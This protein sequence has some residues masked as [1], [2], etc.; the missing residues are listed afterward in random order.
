MLIKFRKQMYSHINKLTQHCHN[1][2]CNDNSIKTE[3]ENK[4]DF[5]CFMASKKKKIIVVNKNYLI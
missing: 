1:M 3:K 5:I 2:F 4:H